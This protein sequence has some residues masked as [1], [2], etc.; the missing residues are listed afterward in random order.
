[1][2]GIDV[3]RIIKKLVDRAGLNAAKYAGHA[4]SVAIA[5]ASER[6][7]IAPDRAPLGSDGWA[8]HAGREFDSGK[9]RGQAGTLEAH[10]P[11][12]AVWRVRKRTSR[13]AIRWI[14]DG[15]PTAQ[16]STPPA[17]LPCDL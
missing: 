7:A 12:N 14:L 6:S 8:L 5:G 2:P 11:G 13:A 17:D 3:V 16:P 9:W 10:V 15:Q 4:T 1:L